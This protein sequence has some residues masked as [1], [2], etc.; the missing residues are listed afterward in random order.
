MSIAL[1]CQPGLAAAN[2]AASR[3][4]KSK[5][6]KQAREKLEMSDTQE[7]ASTCHTLIYNLAAGHYG[8]QNR[9]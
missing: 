5:W 8:K 2:E 6:W 4:V 1:V 9:H 3:P 7:R